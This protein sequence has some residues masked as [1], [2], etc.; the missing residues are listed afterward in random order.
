MK[1]DKALLLYKGKIVTCWYLNITRDVDYLN[2][3]DKAYPNGVRHKF[4]LDYPLE[5]FRK[6]VGEDIFSAILYR[7]N[8]E[9]IE[10]PIASCERCRFDSDLTG[11]IGR[12]N[13]LTL[14]EDIV[15]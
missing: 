9:H 5:S 13:L 6:A 14:P 8:E 12:L 11:S 1:H 15:W 3:N 2:H 7:F 4:R 10:V